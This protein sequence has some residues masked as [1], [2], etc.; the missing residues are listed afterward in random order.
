[1]D[2]IVRFVTGGALIAVIPA[3]ASRASAA[4]AGIIALIPLVTLTG[5]SFLARDQGATA[6]QR[7]SLAALIALPAVGAFLAT[8]YS[9]LRSGWDTPP[10][11]AIGMCA[12]LVIAAPVAAILSRSFA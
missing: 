12:W 8:T 9:A 3:V 2:F 7:A 10:S 1:M 5:F 4:L 6:V 11:L